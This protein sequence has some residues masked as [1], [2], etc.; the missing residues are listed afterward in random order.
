MKHLKPLSKLPV[1]ASDA[2]PTSLLIVFLQDLLGA[3]LT[4]F[5]AKETGGIGAGV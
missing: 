3:L 1:V 4:L 2:I 5:T